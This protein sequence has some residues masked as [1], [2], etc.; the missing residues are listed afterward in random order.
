MSLV[1]LKSLL[2]KHPYPPR[3]EAV[4][5]HPLFAHFPTFVSLSERFQKATRRLECLS[6][7]LLFTSLLVA[8]FHRCRFHVFRHIPTY[9][10]LPSLSKRLEVL[11][12]VWTTNLA[13][14]WGSYNS[15]LHSM[16]SHSIPLP[17][18]VHKTR[19]SPRQTPH[20]KDSL[21]DSLVALRDS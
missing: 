8:F 4:F 2:E 20:T 3:F 13:S 17:L 14:H 7:F 15:P 11:C 10:L 9:P 18:L 12:S 1:T 6:P 5:F 21:T 19:F 16:S